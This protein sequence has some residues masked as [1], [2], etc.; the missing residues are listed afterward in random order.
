[1]IDHEFLILHGVSE[2]I[3]FFVDTS[4]F[5]Y[6]SVNGVQPER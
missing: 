1:M 2:K 3:N 5:S 6:N 4:F